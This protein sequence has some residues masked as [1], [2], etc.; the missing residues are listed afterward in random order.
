MK[1]ILGVL[2][3]TFLISC[4]KEN[5]TVTKAPAI[6]YVNLHDTAVASGQV[7]LDLNIDSKLDL[8]FYIEYVSAMPHDFGEFR[9]VPQI[10][11]FVLATA[12][13]PKVFNKNDVIQH[14][15]NPGFT[16]SDDPVIL[17]KRFYPVEPENGYWEGAWKNSQNKYLGLQLTKDNKKYSA[18]VRIS[19]VNDKSRM[20][21]HDAGISKEPGV[22]IVAGQIE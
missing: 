6:E 13:T 16:W 5:P 19:V 1:T 7:V 18:W 21:L 17:V 2:L 10:E 15:N 12:A 9:V 20:I 14:E 8:L 11:S 4:G 3:I 22:N